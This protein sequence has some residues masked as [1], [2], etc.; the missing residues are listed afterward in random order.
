MWTSK[1]IKTDKE[2]KEIYI[3]DMKE[4]KEITKKFNNE[5]HIHL[6]RFY[7]LEWKIDIDWFL[8]NAQEVV[9]KLFQQPWENNNYWNIDNFREFLKKWL[10]L[11]I[12]DYNLDDKTSKKLIDSTFEFWYMYWEIVEFWEETTDWVII[13]LEKNRHNIQKKE[14]I[15][16]LVEKDYEIFFW[17]WTKGKK[18]NTKVWQATND[19]IEIF[20]N[21]Y[22]GSLDNNQR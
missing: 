10:K 15:K 11:S 21:W 14:D 17:E 5:M 12:L 8:N 20:S 9:I 7:N 19:I 22:Y 16:E 13:Y 4:A 18:L 6:K 1:M 3:Q 2:W